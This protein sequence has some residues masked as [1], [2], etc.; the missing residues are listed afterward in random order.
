MINSKLEKMRKAG[1]LAA[2]LLDYI[3]PFV[4]V[5]VST[6]YL[7]KLCHEYT[8]ENNARPSPLGYMGYP[9]S[10][11]TS[12]NHVVCHGIPSAKILKNGDI[13]NIDVTVELNGYH[14][15]TSRMFFVGDA[16]SLKAKR[17]VDVTY[18]AMFKGIEVVRPGIAI[19]QIGKVI[20]DY[21]EEQG[22]SVV[23]D[24]SGHGIG[25]KMH[26]PSLEVLHYF[27]EKNDKILQEG[28][29]FTIEPMVNVG[30]YR[31]KILSDGWTAVTKD[32]SL[33]AQFEHTIYVNSTGYEIMTLS[34]KGYTKPPF[35]I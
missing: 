29:F 17:L 10:V 24:F 31:V 22:Y 12:V 6:E 18:N 28:M 8:L 27:H 3:T 4:K 30:D 11:C 20:Q 26:D 15:D 5:G 34:E 7:D 19:N 21:V 35:L 32:K 2:K 16:V 13:V 25:E 23:R 33:S 1:K 14:G 9:K